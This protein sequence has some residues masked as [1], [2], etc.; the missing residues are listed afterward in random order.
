MLVL[1]RLLMN[2]QLQKRLLMRVMVMR[3]SKS[4]EFDDVIKLHI[5]HMESFHLGDNQ[6]VI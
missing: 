6:Y 1:H 2:I 4:N 5:V 3:I